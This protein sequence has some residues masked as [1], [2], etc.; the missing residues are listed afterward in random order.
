M[1]FPIAGVDLSPVYLVGVGFVVG[2]LGGFF[3]VGGSFLDGLIRI[4]VARAL[5]APTGW[6][7]HL[8]LDGVL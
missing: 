8:Y 1:H 3:G 4:D 6:R 2:C 7:L 5:R